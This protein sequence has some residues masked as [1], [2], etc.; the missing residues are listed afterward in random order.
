[1]PGRARILSA[2]PAIVNRYHLCRWHHRAHRRWGTGRKN[3]LQQCV[4]SLSDRKQR[5]QELELPIVSLSERIQPVE[6]VSLEHSDFVERQKKNIGNKT[7][8]R[9]MEYWSTTCSPSDDDIPSLE[10]E[11]DLYLGRGSHFGRHIRS[12]S[13]MRGTWGVLNTATPQTK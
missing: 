9:K 3:L 4:S 11:A 13:R 6:P 12:N 10:R 1:M 7:P 2:I 8:Q 5:W